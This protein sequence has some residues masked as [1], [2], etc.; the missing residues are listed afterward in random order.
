MIDLNKKKWLSN[1]EKHAVYARKKDR[2][3]W[4]GD[5]INCTTL[6]ATK[7]KKKELDINYNVCGFVI[8]LK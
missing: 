5:F 2:K 3:L 7:K 4:K 1:N 8:K 6:K